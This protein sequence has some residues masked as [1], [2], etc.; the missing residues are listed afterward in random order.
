MEVADEAG[1][2]ELFGENRF[3]QLFGDLFR[4][5]RGALFMGGPDI[6]PQLFGEE[7]NL[8]TRV[9]DPY[10]HYLELSFLFHLLGGYQDPHWEPLL[11]Q[12]PGYLVSGICL[13]MQTLNVATGGTLVQDIPT[14]IYG[15]RTAEGVLALPEDRQHRNYRGM[16]VAG[17]AETTSYHFHRIRLTEG[18]FLADETS[19]GGISA[20]M[21]LSSHHQAVEE[22]GTGLE[23]A[24]V[25][26]DGKVV[27]AIGHSE[28]PHVFGVQF[29]P[30]K[31]GLF[32]PSIVHP[33]DCA[34]SIS[35]HG[36]IRDTPSFEFHLAYWK[37][38][39][40]ILRGRETLTRSR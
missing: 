3:T 2:G 36:T 22:L 33:V 27:E 26:M 7:V 9:T 28:Y 23:V 20:P 35:F 37:Y 15:I 12:R 40:K 17:C 34:D 1:P 25:S 16:A 31:P 39:G 8:L 21:V 13:G 18:S 5:S 6:P 29:H 30:E 19:F 4:S 10:R 38:L 24:A 11:R 32:D 14:E